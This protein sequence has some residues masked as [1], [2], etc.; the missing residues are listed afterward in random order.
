MPTHYSRGSGPSSGQT[1][2]TTS[3]AGPGRGSRTGPSPRAGAGSARPATAPGNVKFPVCP[4]CGRNP[5]DT[6][7]TVLVVKT[8][9]CSRCASA[10]M[11]MV[12]VMK[13]FL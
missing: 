4:V 1:K 13:R 7:V 6:E 12:Q 10:G 8:R 2:T 3:S 5:A 9:I 11:Q